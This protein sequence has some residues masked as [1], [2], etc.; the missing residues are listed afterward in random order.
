[1]Q[2]F[3]L[4]IDLGGM[5]G[6][7]GAGAGPSAG[8]Q[9]AEGVFA[10]VLASAGLEGAGAAVAA[11]PVNASASGGIPAQKAIDAQGLQVLQ[12]GAVVEPQ[13]IDAE[14]A[15]PLPL[16]QVPGSSPAELP[17]PLPGTAAGEA[18]V[19]GLPVADAPVLDGE[20]GA[21]ATA[22]VV[23]FVMPAPLPA[24]QPIV[25][26]P[27][28]NGFQDGALNG[29]DG[30]RGSITPALPDLP[31]PGGQPQPSAPGTAQ[32]QVDA[33]VSAPLRLPAGICRPPRLERLPRPR[34]RVFLQC[35][36]P[37]PH[38]P[39]LWALRR[40]CFSNWK[41]RSRRRVPVLK[42]RLL[43]QASPPAALK[44]WSQ[45][46]LPHLHAL[47]LQALPRLTLWPP[48]QLQTVLLMFRHRLL[49]LRCSHRLPGLRLTCVPSRFRH[50]WQQIAHPRSR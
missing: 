12:P 21:D 16:P 39:P 38:L 2:A 49:F 20:S 25:A 41:M 1:M 42:P 35:L 15:L 43:Q 32:P 30:L 13:A 28:Q 4:R 11:A 22:M 26:A 27:A 40:R 46:F 23:A 24:P 34:S 44:L 47:Q 31:Q 37:M 6:P 9:A 5:S 19:D 17:S 10:G 7:A 45:T 14:A 50:L 36:P 18:V 29:V 48:R 8:G 33:S 3:Q